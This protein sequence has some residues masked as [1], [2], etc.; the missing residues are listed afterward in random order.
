MAIHHQREGHTRLGFVLQPCALRY[1]GFAPDDLSTA[2]W[3]VVVYVA[4]QLWVPPEALVA[5]G[6]RMPTRTKHL[7]QLQRHLRFR[8]PLSLD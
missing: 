3:E 4:R 8:K 1:L 2:P 6:H 7:Q 5:Y